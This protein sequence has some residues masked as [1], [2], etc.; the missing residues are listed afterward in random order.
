MNYSEE[1][2]EDYIDSIYEDYKELCD[3]VIDEILKDKKSLTKTNSFVK[4]CAVFYVLGNDEARRS[5][6]AEANLGD[7]IEDYIPEI[8]SLVE[9][10]IARSPKNFV[11]PNHKIINALAKHGAAGYEEIAATKLLKKYPD[12]KTTATLIFDE[13][14]NLPKNFTQYDRAVF[15]A[16]CSLYEAGN[17]SFTPTMVFRTMTGRTNEEFIKPSNIER[18]TKSIEKQR[19]ALV[20]ID[21]K[22]EFEKRKLPYLKNFDDY[23]LPVK[24]ATVV[25]N[26]AEVKGYVFWG[27]PM[28]YEYCEATKQIITVPIHLLNTKSVKS[29]PEIIV[30]KEYLIRQIELLKNGYRDN[31]GILYE[32]IFSECSI[33]F[34]ENDR[35]VQKRYRDYIKKLLEEWKEKK[36]I[37]AYKEYKQGC[38]LVGVEI[39]P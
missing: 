17:R 24:S 23:I 27:K 14:I 9:K 28:L 22:T 29:T 3:A 35:T 39:I 36:H 8:A 33:P 7:Y 10:A 32:T 37:K 38:K 15:N 34:K 11:M 4:A 30:I 1:L 2:L 26:G 21:C 19:T 12:I 5:G 16:V 13:N 20:K 31:N 18:V 6:K 25:I